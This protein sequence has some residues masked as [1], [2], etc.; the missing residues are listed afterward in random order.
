[1][2]YSYSGVLSCDDFTAYNGDLVKAQHKCQAHLLCHIKKLI[3][4]PG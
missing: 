4:I 2:G 1:M 3:K